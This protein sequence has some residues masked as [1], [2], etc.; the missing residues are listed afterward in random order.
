MGVN[1]A[2]DYRAHVLSTFPIE[3][4]GVLYFSKH[5]CSIFAFPYQ[6]YW[7]VQPNSALPGKEMAF[8]VKSCTGSLK[9]AGYLA[10]CLCW[11]LVS[12]TLP[13]VLL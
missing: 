8:A 11:A 6:V 9:M 4:I 3:V 10:S 5:V 12:E 1:T 7:C 13:S 2:L